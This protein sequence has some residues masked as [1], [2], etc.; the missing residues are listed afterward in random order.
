M[1]M[2]EIAEVRP[3]ARKSTAMENDART[4]EYFCDA[5]CGVYCG[6][7]PEQSTD[8]VFNADFS[9]HALTGAVAATITSPGHKAHRAR[10]MVRS[11]PDDNLF[12][13]F[14]A[15]SSFAAE[16]AGRSWK[17]GTATPFLLDNDQE[18]HLD[19]DR[20]RRMRLH[21]LRFSKGGVDFAPDTLRRANLAIASTSTGRQLGLQ[22]RLMCEAIEAGNLVLADLMTRPVLGLLSILIDETGEA[23]SENRR[24]DEIKSIALSHIEDGGFSLDHLAKIFR[25]SVRTLQSRFAANDESFSGWLQD[26]RLDLARDRLLSPAYLGRS[27]DA[28]AMSCG[29][30]DASHFYRA[31][32]QRFS[33]PPGKLRH[34]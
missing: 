16:H 32:K 22:M 29:F 30:R 24:L 18:F 9:A 17:V 26:R 21:S 34:P 28:I 1:A 15:F 33:M 20:S 13:N 8:Q 12:L 7:Q 31:F 11:R 27:I 4:F 25:C 19:F 2:G 23:D 10:S 5:I 14:S 6:I 3:I